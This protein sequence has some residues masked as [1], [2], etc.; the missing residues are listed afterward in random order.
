MEKHQSVIVFQGEKYE[1]N[2]LVIIVRRTDRALRVISLKFLPAKQDG[3]EN[4][5]YDHT[6]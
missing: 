1:R 3:H 2:K 6:R 5:E 4:Q